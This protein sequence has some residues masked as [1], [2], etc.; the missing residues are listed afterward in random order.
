[1]S[2]T[3]HLGLDQRARVM[4]TDQGWRMEVYRAVRRRACALRV[5]ATAACVVGRRRG[6]SKPST[7]ASPAPTR[8]AASRRQDC[9]VPDAYFDRHPFARSGFDQRKKAKGRRRRH[10]DECRC[11]TASVGL[12]VSE[13]I[14]WRRRNSADASN[15]TSPVPRRASGGGSGT[16]T[17]VAPDRSPRG[18]SETCCRCSRSRTLMFSARP[19]PG[20]DIRNVALR[21]GV[22]SSQ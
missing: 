1:M 10:V 13:A 2:K 17:T 12:S 18:R 4:V 9:A 19:E 3:D 8:R 11:A 6:R 20:S 5:V 22:C 16:L 21:L 7:S 14:R 15:K